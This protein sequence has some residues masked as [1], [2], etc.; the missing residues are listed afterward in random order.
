ML[1]WSCST[2][3]NDVQIVDE[4]AST[5]HHCITEKINTINLKDSSLLHDQLEVDEDLNCDEH[6]R[7]ALNREKPLGLIIIHCDYWDADHPNWLECAYSF[8]V[9]KNDTFFK[10]LIEYNRMVPLL[11]DEE[12]LKQQKDWFL[13]G[14][15]KRYE[16][17]YTEDDFDDFQVFRDRIT[18]RIYIRGSES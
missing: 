18:G 5:Q 4:K 6:F 16:G 13:P 7:K 12:Y 10:E 14:N 9:E 17:Y 15:I 2:D 11:N 8:E 1:F 3:Q